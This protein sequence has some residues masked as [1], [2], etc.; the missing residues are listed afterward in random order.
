MDKE[1]FLQLIRII[2]DKAKTDEE[3]IKPLVSRLTNMD[4]EDIYLFDEYLDEIYDDLEDDEKRI[5]SEVSHKAYELKHETCYSPVHFRR[6][7]E[8]W[9]IISKCDFTKKDDS[10][11]LEPLID[12]LASVDDE[13]TFMFDECLEELM[14]FLDDEKFF[15]LC[16]DED[17]F[18]SSDTF[19]YTRRG[20]IARGKE[21]FFKAIKGDDP[22]LWDFDISLEDL[23]YVIWYVW[24]K[25]Q[26]DNEYEVDKYERDQRILNKK[27][28]RQ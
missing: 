1:T 5:L 19:L 16:V 20:V 9:N 10:D 21:Y 11:A 26:R 18:C 14:D 15:N 27:E 2:D 8:F 23:G 17:G 28:E 4:D 22:K 13:Y 7:N 25:K 6:Y 12:Y 3:R 24:D